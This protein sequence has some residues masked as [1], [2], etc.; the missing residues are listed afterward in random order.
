MKYLIFLLSLLPVFTYGQM[1]LTGKVLDE[2]ELP[3]EFA[4]VALFSL[5]D[6]SFLQ[7][8]TTNVTGSFY[9]EVPVVSK[10][11][12]VISFVGYESVVLQSVQGDVGTIRLT[13]QAIQLQEAVVTV[14]RPTVISKPDRL[15]VN[16]AGSILSAALDGMEML[17]KTPGLISTAR[18]GISVAGKGAPVIYIDGKK[19]QDMEEVKMLNP[20]NI[21]SIE[22]IDNPSS[23]YEADGHAVLLVHTIRRH[24]LYYVRLGGNLLQGRRLGEGAYVDASFSKKKISTNLYYGFSDGNGKTYEKNDR[25]LANEPY[26]HSYTEEITQ[27][28]KHTYKAAVDYDI[29]SSHRIGIQANG[30]SSVS[31]SHS[32]KSTSFFNEELSPFVTKNHDKQSSNLVNASGYYTFD[33]DTLGQQFRL[34]GDYTYQNKDRHQRFRNILDGSFEENAILNLNNNDNKVSIY[35]V[36]ADYVKPFGSRWKLEAG[37]KYYF[38]KNNTVTDLRGSTNLD[39]LYETKEHNV[40]EY[41]SFSADLSQSLSMRVGLRGEYLKREGF[42]DQKETV[43]T[44]HY[45]LFPS[46]QISYAPSNGMKVGFSYTKRISRPSLNL[47]DPS[48]IVDSLYNRQ[49]NPYLKSENVHAFQLSF[50][51]IKSLTFRVGYNRLVNPVY[52]LLYQDE[53][54]PEIMKVRF[55]NGAA[56]NSYSASV[57]WD[58][59]LFKWWS[60]SAYLSYWQSFYKYSDMHGEMLWNK[61]PGWYGSL[62]SSFLLPLDIAL[63]A[64]FYYNS[65]GSGGSLVEKHVWNLYASIRRGFFNN[66]L[67][68]TLSANDIFRKTVSEQYSVL[69]GNNLNVW[70]GDYTYVNLSISYKFGKSNY[71]SNHQSIS[72][73]ERSRL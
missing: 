8:G 62:Q 1:S 72:G 6:S 15:V 49:G 45:D 21:K 7:G 27:S 30:F 28:A 13:P 39:Q 67:N 48:L 52:F 33:M 68:V 25:Y 59:D 35:E 70:D 14:K 10:G 2:K 19:V 61:K 65:G 54:R 3:V 41:I 26:L 55:E 17:Q 16:V 4:N 29:T 46:L 71:R 66:A 51:P 40:A 42:A 47:L 11:Y 20:Q 53:T 31:R 24:D 69:A 12:A 63:D 56:T 37:A 9:I 34:V 58:K 23:A 38:I 32:D 73:T 64:G 5:P 22:V 43:N 44:G 50:M 36:M 57:I 18:G 60:L